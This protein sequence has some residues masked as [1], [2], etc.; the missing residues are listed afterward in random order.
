MTKVQHILVPTD[1]SEGALKAAQFA[2]DMARA[3]NAKVTVLLVQDERSVLSEAWN[4]AIGHQT[5]DSA[6]G[7]VDVARTA[8]EENARQNA[9]AN[10]GA[11][12]GDLASGHELVQVWG[13]PANDICRYAAEHSVDLIV[14]GSQGLSALG[15]AILGS[16]SHAVVNSADCAVTIVK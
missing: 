10:T 8:M 7:A 5:A 13:H 15:R 6:S 14:M 12:L 2:G 11:V 3:L 9:L 4:A 1:G 16:V